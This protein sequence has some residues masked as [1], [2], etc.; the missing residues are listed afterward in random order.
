MEERS[1]DT[2]CSLDMLAEVASATLQNDPSL[3]SNFHL[4]RSRNSIKVSGSSSRKSVTSSDKLTLDQINSLSEKNLFE[5]F[6]EHICDEMKRNYSFQC[7]LIPE[8]CSQV[9]KSFGN[10]TQARIKMKAHLLNHIKELI[11]AA[12]DTN[13]QE[14]FMAEPLHVRRK[15]LREVNRK[16]TRKKKQSKPLCN[17]YRKDNSY[18]QFPNNSESLNCFRTG[19]QIPVKTGRHG[20]LNSSSKIDYDSWCSGFK[21]CLN[22]DV[23][24]EFISD[25]SKQL[26][27]SSYRTSNDQRFLNT[28]QMLLKN[29]SSKNDLNS[30][31]TESLLRKRQT[32][33]TQS[34]SK[35]NF[36]CAFQSNTSQECNLNFEST[37]HLNCDDLSE[38]EPCLP[39]H[40]DHT[41]TSVNA[42]ALDCDPSSSGESSKP[43]N[44]IYK[45]PF[46]TKRTVH[47]CFK[48]ESPLIIP[49]PPFPYVY[50]PILPHIAHIQE[51]GHHFNTSGCLCKN[52][53]IV[54][55]LLESCNKPKIAQHSSLQGNGCY[56]NSG[57]NA[58][59]NSEVDKN[60]PS[61]LDDSVSENDESNSAASDDK[62]SDSS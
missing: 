25:T 8:K 2:F 29:W 57:N 10:E 1:H 62:L 23:S 51:V 12:N 30:S 47:H 20:I 50:N 60:A 42:K 59:E 7:Y 54:E 4:Q 31:F 32:S 19:N 56:T 48:R 52:N 44:K 3:I 14:I 11:A 5:M 6:S 18:V 21:K 27:Y 9:Y 61:D 35:R 17:K 13:N 58:T 39:I 40:H 55:G 28:D 26:T 24:S 22:E 46:Q 16:N 15:R 33:R 49:T 36:S 34:D 38:S 45:E 41:Y 43:A 37:T 53:D